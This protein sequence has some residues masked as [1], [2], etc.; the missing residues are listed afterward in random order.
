MNRKQY[1][2]DTAAFF[3][4]LEYRYTY[5]NGWPRCLLTDIIIYK[6][7]IINETFH[8]PFAGSAAE[9]EQI[10]GKKASGQAAA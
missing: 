4:L 8:C 9:V 10:D 6:V 1:H 5:S 7:M 3:G 2:C